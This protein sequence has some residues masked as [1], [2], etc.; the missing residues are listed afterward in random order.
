MKQKCFDLSDSQIL[1]LLTARLAKKTLKNRLKKLLKKKK[2]IYKKIQTIKGSEWTHDTKSVQ[3]LYNRLRHDLGTG[4]T[5]H[6]LK[7]QSVMIMDADTDYV[8]AR[9]ADGSWGPLVPMNKLDGALWSGTR[10]FRQIEKIVGR[11]PETKGGSHIFSLK[12]AITH[13]KAIGKNSSIPAL[14]RTAKPAIKPNKKNL[15][16]AD[17]SI[18]LISMARVQR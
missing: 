11:T 9:K 15:H 17:L 4:P 1:I 6:G 12:T 16:G 13:I 8:R 18:T 5:V 10:R 3:D 2:R 7:N 14:A